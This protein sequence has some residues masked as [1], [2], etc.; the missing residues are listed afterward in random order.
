MTRSVLTL[1]ALMLASQ[2]ADA[3]TL[4]QCE[5]DSECVTA[6]ARWSSPTTG[7][8]VDFYRLEL[9]MELDTVWELVWVGS[10]TFMTGVWPSNNRI[11]VQ[12]VDSLGRAGLYS[13]PSDL[14]IYPNK[15][16][17]IWLSDTR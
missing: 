16:A 11:R 3:Q 17:Q 5:D 15:I 12:G 14:F 8:P 13:E 2:L 10:D 7:S 1:F 6:V 9:R 4:V